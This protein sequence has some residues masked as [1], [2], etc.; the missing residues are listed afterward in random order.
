MITKLEKWYSTTAFLSVP[1]PAFIFIIE[2]DTTWSNSMLFIYL[3]CYL[4][5]AV[6]QTNMKGQKGE[7]VGFV[8]YWITR[9]GLAFISIWYLLNKWMNEWMVIMLHLFFEILC[10]YVFI[11]PSYQHPVS[12]HSI[13][14][15]LG[16]HSW[17]DLGF[18]WESY[19]LKTVPCYV[20][21]D[22]GYMSDGPENSWVPVASPCHWSDH[23]QQL[24]I[25]INSLVII[26]VV[27]FPCSVHHFKHHNRKWW[28]RGA[29]IIENV[30]QPSL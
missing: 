16:T 5:F 30:E 18:P 23:L 14:A 17:D 29:F 25:H 3:L 26:M 20:V 2:L 8:N 21:E 4:I 22:L 15:L 6:I 11:Y 10:G 28:R 7:E 1:S 19:Y 13:A 27:S 12:F 24:W 9:G